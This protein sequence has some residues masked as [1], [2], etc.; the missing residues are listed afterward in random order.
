MFGW[1]PGPDDWAYTGGGLQ[2]SSGGW[3]Q[4][5]YDARVQELASLPKWTMEMAEQQAFL[6]MQSAEQYS[7][8]YQTIAPG[9]TLDEAMAA[10]RAA[11][12][13]VEPLPPAGFETWDAY[14][15]EIAK[16]QIGGEYNPIDDTGEGDLPPPEGDVP[17]PEGD[18]PPPEGELPA[19]DWSG[20]LEAEP[21]SAYY[22]YSGEWDSPRQGGYYQNQFT[23]IYNDYLGQ[24]GSQ[25]RGGGAPTNQWTDYLGDFDWD[26]WYRENQTYE[27]R[28]PNRS[29]FT[30]QTSWR[31][32]G[33]TGF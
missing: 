26:A 1:Q 13:G 7:A 11:Q 25:V 6:E 27:Q 3:T 9:A 24:L 20:Y 32:P 10:R 21:A 4:E 15:A 28:N 16:F 12:T 22:S 5:Q 29:S 14:N 30:P 17:P 23:D 19:E 33:I 31:M 18:V 2:L 8:A